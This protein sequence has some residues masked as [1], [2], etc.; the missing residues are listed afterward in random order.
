[1]ANAAASSRRSGKV[2]PGKKLLGRTEPRLWTPPLR[3]LTR[4]TTRGYEVIDFARE[5]LGEPLL[6][7]QEFAVI[8]GLELLPEGTFRFRTVLAIVARQNGKTHLSK[9]LALWRLFVDGARLVLGAAQDL[10]IAREVLDKANESVDE[11]AEL[12]DEKLS[13]LTANGKESLNL[14]GGRR[15]LIK[16]SNRS[17]GRG[18]SVDHLTLDEVR[19]QRDW[20]AWSSLSKT[21]M[22]R[23]NGQIWALS[24]AGD[25]Q[26]VVLNHLR[27][28]AGAVDGG[29]G[30]TVMGDA[31]D[32]S[33]ALFEWSAPEGCELDD[34]QAWAQANPAL[35][36]TLSHTA[37]R[38][39]LATDP[40]EV[41]RTEVL[42]QKVDQLDGAVDLAAWKACRDPSMTLDAVQDRIVL[43]L[44]VAP[45]GKHVAL[46]A[47][48]EV[49]GVVRVEV[50]E[51]WDST[52]AARDELPALREEY[53]PKAGAWFPSGPAAAL[54][55]LLRSWP[56]WVEIKGAAVAEA[57]QGLADL[58][59]GR[60]VIHPGDPL[61]DAHIAGA[62]KYY[63]GDGWRFVRRGAGH[64]DAAYAAA[65]AVHTVLT[66]PEEQPAP[67]FGV[68]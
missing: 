38:S 30:V 5:V 41:F 50:V 7:W 59:R 26:S 6:P 36:R 35:G 13:Y 2:A 32:E 57:C 46:L 11:V 33:I 60:R 45:D 15:Y 48:G 4:K 9:V 43:C 63:Q 68:V 61:L 66:L 62:S 3:P 37:I 17:A 44:D 65:G 19:E 53:Q 52:E 40:P 14:D 56:E 25:D 49:A 31:R 58:V 16:A 21:I 47:A 42:S 51:A 27:A 20:A 23:A 1:M 24:N 39:A 8:H 67:W 18:L 34:E 28:A 22:A 10:G 55:P 29:D 12:A 64:V 54:A